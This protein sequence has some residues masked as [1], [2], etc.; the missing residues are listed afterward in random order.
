[1]TLLDAAHSKV[2]TRRTRV[3]ARHLAEL[4]PRA[5]RCLDVGCGDGT[6]D[7]LVKEL[8]P[9]LSIQGIDVLVRPTT[10]VQVTPFDGLKIP[11]SDKSFD[12]VMFV[13]VLHHTSDP[14]LLLREAARVARTSIIIKDHALEGPL[15]APTLRFMDWVG[16]ERHGVAL[17]YNYWRQDQWD[18]CFRA[19]SLVVEE[20]RTRI[21]LYPF[22]ASLFFERQ[23]HFL[24]R[25]RV[26]KEH[27]GSDGDAEL[28][29]SP[30]GER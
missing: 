4:A 29:A 10:R 2:F 1:M 23:L 21:G 11:F 30:S 17:P 15:A 13:D 26:P 18:R 28:L 22:P 24:S 3:L 25:I 7:A 19:L 27:R 9:D 8:R 6:I 12:V 20:S 5:A 16:N 14:T